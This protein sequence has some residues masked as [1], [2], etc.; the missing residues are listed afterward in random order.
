V[1]ESLKYNVITYSLFDVAPPKKYY[2]KRVIA[3]EGDVIRITN[4]GVYV[5]DVLIE[6]N[7]VN[8]SETPAYPMPGMSFDSNQWLTS[9][10]EGIVVPEDHVFV[11]GDNRNHST[12]SRALGFVPENDILGK[13]FE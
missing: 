6:E 1:K 9:L 7:Y 13:V 11:M 2:I 3:V 4:E 5:N 10:N 12:D 8:N